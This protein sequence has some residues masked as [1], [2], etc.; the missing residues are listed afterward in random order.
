MPSTRRDDVERTLE[1]VWRM[2]SARIVA[3]LTRI[4][5]D[6]GLAEDVAQDAFEAALRQWPSSGIPAN[7]AGWL[8]GTAKHRAIDAIR[9]RATL[10]RKT[11]ELGHELELA[12]GAD[13]D[14]AAAIDDASIADDLLRLMFIC[15][16]PL[17]SLDAR[18][19]LTLRLLGGLSTDEIARAFLTSTTTVGQRISR[20]KRTLSEAHVPFEVPQGEEVKTRLEAVL[21]VIYLVFNEGYSA[22]AGD[23]AI[24]P[25]LCEEALRLGRVLAGLAPDEP[26]VHGL[27]ALMENP[28]LADAS[29][30]RSKRGFDTATGAASR[31]LGWCAH[32][33]GTRGIGAGRRWPRPTRYLHPPGGHRGLPCPGAQR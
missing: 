3:A 15:C 4:V 22:T 6:V 25:A 2:E 24:R 10:E 27:V 23:D 21:Q 9:R 29:P 16:H 20:A 32:R 30:H 11:T 33:P 8:M 31:A 13:P 18:V 19:A 28:G 1:A 7:P 26:E 17:L 14:L 5:R 12:D